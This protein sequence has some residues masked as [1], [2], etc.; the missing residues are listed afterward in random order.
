[1]TCRSNQAITFALAF[2]AM[3]SQQAFAQSSV[4]LY[5]SLDAGLLY[6]S[7]TAGGGAHQFSMVD[8]GTS[9]SEFG[10]RGS[11]DLGGGL[12]AIFVLGKR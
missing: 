10:I 3:G 7:R 12:K 9:A 2:F 8:S 4:T 5:G 1:M 6:T 11:E